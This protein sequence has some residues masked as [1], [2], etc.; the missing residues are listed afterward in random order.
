V[1]ILTRFAIARCKFIKLCH[2][3]VLCMLCGSMSIDIY[4]NLSAVWALLISD[5]LPQP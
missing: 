3:G 2:V 5:A 4:Y 1:N